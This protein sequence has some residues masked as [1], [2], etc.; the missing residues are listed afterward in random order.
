VA[1][2]AKKNGIVRAYFK[3]FGVLVVG[4]ATIFGGV[5][6]WRVANMLFD[7]LI[8]NKNENVGRLK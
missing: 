3:G 4:A 1:R 5:F 2:K 7:H 6:A 8:A